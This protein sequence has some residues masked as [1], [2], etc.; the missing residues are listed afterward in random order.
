MAKPQP[1]VAKRARKR[2]ALLNDELDMAIE[3][4][5]ARQCGPDR[6]KRWTLLDMCA[7]RPANDRQRAARDAWASGQSLTLT[8][9]AGTGK[10]F[11]SSYFAC[12]SVF[13]KEAEQDHIVIVRS[14]VQGREI[15]FTPGTVDE[16]LAEYEQPYQ[17]AMATIFGREATY[18]DMKEAKKV[19]FKSTSFLRGVTWNNAII[20]VD[21]AQN[22]TFH[23]INS[24]MTRVGKNSRIIVSGDTRQCDLSIRSKEASG[25]QDFINI[26]QRIGGMTCVDFQKEDIVRSKF[27]KDWITASEEY[28]NEKKR[29]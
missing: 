20:M 23:E 6:R 9:H 12:Q 4:Q 22:M 27:V 26:M 1:A 19:V 5:A 18:S 14:A 2:A 11:L 3:D 21:E 16:K 24:V 10:T 17:E 28:F 8:G 7:L 15:G 13:D 25:L 29:A